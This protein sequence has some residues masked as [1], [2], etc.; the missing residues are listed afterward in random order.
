MRSKCCIIGLLLSGAAL[1]TA[2]DAEPFFPKPAYFKRHF[3]T[4]SPQ[5]ELKTP[6][7][8]DDYSVSGKLELSLKNYLQLVMTNNPDISIQ[9]VSVEIQKD[10]ITRAF[11]VFDPL[12]TARFTT[13]RQQSPSNSALNGASAPNTLSQPLSLN[14]SQLLSTGTTYNVNFGNTRLS[15][16]SSFATYNPGHSSNLNFNISQPLLRGRGAY[17]TRLPITIARSRLKASQFSLEDQVIQLISLAEVAYWNV[18][19]ANQNLRVSEEALALADTALK[20]SKREL[21]L[22]AISSLEIYQPEANYATAQISVVQA[23]YNVQ[24]AEAALRRQMGADLDPK[25]RDIPIVLTETVDPPTST[26]SFDREALV[27][28]AINRRPD[29]R[30]QSE[31]LA[32]DD[33]TIA[34][35]HNALLPNLALTA[36][37][38]SAGQGGTFYNR[39]N[40]F[41]ADGTQSSVVSV[42]PGGFGDAFTQM[43]GF[44]YPTYGFG[45][46]L[47][48]PIRDR[49]ASANLADAVVNKKL[50]T[51]RANSISKNIRLQVLQAVT[52]VENSKASVELAKVARDLAQKRVDADQKR[53]ELGTT[54]IFFVL[55]SQNDLVTAESALVR[56]SINYRINLMT[57][58]QRTGELLDERGIQ[59]Q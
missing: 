7:R 18:V 25:Y 33:L 42:L 30:S 54:T 39:Q 48:L 34:Q 14:Y 35:T 49:V 8:L 53:Y 38:G 5:V 15:T 40:I 50:D 43:F 20:R 51:L 58:L 26:S 27:E 19:S 32:G 46:T 3:G 36:Q 47:Q 56:E 57:L 24:N 37:Y 1:S 2:Q 13:T 12:A 59:I 29:L 44:G 22:G 10:A 28:R 17:F 55:A 31:T 52:Q 11:G 23:R 9:V 4:A 6:A 41:L 45:L 16:N 21:E